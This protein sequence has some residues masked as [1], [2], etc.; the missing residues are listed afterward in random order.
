MTAVSWFD[1]HSDWVRL[2]AGFTLAR[3]FGIAI[4]ALLSIIIVFL[5]EENAL[6][7]A[8]ALIC[9]TVFVGLDVIVHKVGLATE[10]VIPEKVPANKAT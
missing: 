1:R 5:R 7:I 8:I 4:S 10:Q 9:L 3:F 2:F 6:W